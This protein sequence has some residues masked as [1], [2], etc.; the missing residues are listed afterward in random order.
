MNLFFPTESN[1]LNLYGNQRNNIC[2]L[3]NEYFSGEEEYFLFMDFIVVSM[4]NV[5]S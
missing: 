2:A 3:I 1:C 4:A 5:S